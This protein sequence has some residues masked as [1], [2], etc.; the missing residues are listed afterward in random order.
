VLLFSKVGDGKVDEGAVAG[1]THMRSRRGE[2][3]NH[4]SI[5]EMVCMSGCKRGGLR[6]PARESR[7]AAH[8]VRTIAERRIIPLELARDRAAHRTIPR[9]PAS[10]AEHTWRGTEH[11]AS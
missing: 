4:H 3:T 10:R 7:G 2:A 1:Y 8:A 9:H 6:L 11:L 5:S